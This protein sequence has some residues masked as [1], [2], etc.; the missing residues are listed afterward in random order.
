MEYLI[1]LG[2]KL[3]TEK[4]VIEAVLLF[5][6]YIQKKEK[7]LNDLWNQRPILD[8]RAMLREWAEP[9]WW[10]EEC[11]ED[12]NVVWKVFCDYAFGNEQAWEK[13]QSVI[14]ELSCPVPEKPQTY[15]DPST[16]ES[17]TDDPHSKL[18]RLKPGV[19]MEQWDA[20]CEEWDNIVLTVA[21]RSDITRKELIAIMK[22]I[23]LK[24]A[25]LQVDK[26]I[27]AASDCIKYIPP[28]RKKG[29]RY[30]HDDCKIK[31]KGRRQRRKDPKAKMRSDLK[32]LKYLEEEGDLDE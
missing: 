12:A 28:D 11:P 29:A 7:S 10:F 3:D 15:I 20:I 25:A 17:L 23:K 14:S 1:P 27:C 13:I 19:T 4:K 30:C 9:Q 8:F 26:K 31:E 6:K 18:I 24:M 22:P 21:F 16:L 5:E 2:E 32:Y